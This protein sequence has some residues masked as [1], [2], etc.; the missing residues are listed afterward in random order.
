M[1]A[2][3]LR[4]DAYFTKWNITASRAGNRSQ[5][6]LIHIRI[7][8]HHL[9]RNMRHRLFR[10]C[11][12]YRIHLDHYLLS[13]TVLLPVRRCK[14]FNTRKGDTE[15]EEKKERKKKERKKEKKR[16]ENFLY[17]LFFFPF[18]FFFFS[19]FPFSFLFYFIFIIIIITILII[20]KRS[21]CYLL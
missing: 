10:G 16:K 6:T 2:Y 19:S 20:I 13:S 15:R 9:H 7:H 18:H 4:I 17:S 8:I 3:G 14:V 12:A 21:L 5:T 1:K 11:R